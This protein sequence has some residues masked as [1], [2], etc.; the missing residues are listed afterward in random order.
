MSS[1]LGSDAD[2]SPDNEFEDN[3]MNVSE[4]SDSGGVRPVAVRQNPAPQSRQLNE[5]AAAK[6]TPVSKSLNE[7]SIARTQNAQNTENDL[8]KSWQAEKKH[9]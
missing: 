5:G 9:H 8:R 3:S 1:G 2:N 7:G 4:N 6:N